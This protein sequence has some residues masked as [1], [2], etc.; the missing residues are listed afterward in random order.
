MAKSIMDRV[1]TNFTSSQMAAVKQARDAQEVNRI[2][3]LNFA[4]TSACSA[5]LIFEAIPSSKDAGSLNYTVKYGEIGH[6]DIVDHA[7]DVEK[8]LLPLQWAVDQVSI[9]STM[10][11]QGPKLTCP[12]GHHL[13]NNGQNHPYSLRA[14]LHL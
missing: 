8:N 1:T 10:S 6:I 14:T 11:S 2:C 3:V 4:G 12:Q 5:G 7:S 9:F 13:S